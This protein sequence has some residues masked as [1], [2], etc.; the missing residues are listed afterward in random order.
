LKLNPQRLVYV[1]MPKPSRESLKLRFDYFLAPPSRVLVFL[2]SLNNGN[3]IS[4]ICK[5]IFKKYSL[6]EK[7]SFFIRYYHWLKLELNKFVLG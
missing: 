4:K 2:N 5:N 1:E 7:I 6:C 3:G